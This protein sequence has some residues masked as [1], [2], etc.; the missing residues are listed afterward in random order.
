MYACLLILPGTGFQQPERSVFWR[1]TCGS[2]RGECCQG[3]VKLETERRSERV[4][5]FPAGPS[6]HRTCGVPARRC[7]QDQ[8]TEVHRR[9]SPACGR[10]AS[11]NRRQHMYTRWEQPCKSTPSVLYCC[12]VAQVRQ[13][14]KADNYK[15]GRI[16]Q[17]LKATRP[18][19]LEQQTTTEDVDSG[20][21]VS[22]LPRLFGKQAPAGGWEG[23]E[24]PPWVQ[25]ALVASTAETPVRG[26]EGA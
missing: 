4:H 23:V 9:T 16:S 15:A 6:R 26:R 21:D 8:L 2:A 22:G 5:F 13:Q 1:R 7:P 12:F 25:R 10:R 14:L 24:V 18:T 3:L 17:L 19:N 20:M 11:P